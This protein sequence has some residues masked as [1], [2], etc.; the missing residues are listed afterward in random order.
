[1]A[2]PAEASGHTATAS[3]S[4][5]NNVLAIVI[6]ASEWRA[7]APAVPGAK[8]GRPRSGIGLC[9]CLPGCADK[10][11]PADGRG[12]VRCSSRS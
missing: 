1:M 7:G 10:A 2:Q 12:R 8:R 4:M 6:A 9:R 5:D 3:A 11:I